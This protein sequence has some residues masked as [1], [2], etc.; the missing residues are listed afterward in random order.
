MCALAANFVDAGFTPVIDWVVA[1]KGQLETYRSAL[2]SRRL[3]L[4]MLDPGS[5]VCQS[6]NATRPPERQFF[7]DGY[8]QLL[9]SMEGYRDLGWWFDT[10]R[11]NPEETVERILDEA[12]VHAWV[13]R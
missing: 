5:T 11:L 8:D 3:L 6:R 4:V 2:T 10:S 9:A 13:P 7:F 12:L 1:D